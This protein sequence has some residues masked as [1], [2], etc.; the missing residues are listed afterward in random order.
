MSEKQGREKA[1]SDC[2]KGL[3][4]KPSMTAPPPRP[5][6]SFPPLGGRIH[7]S[8]L[9]LILPKFFPADMSGRKRLS[10]VSCVHLMQKGST[11]SIMF[12][13]VSH[14]CASYFLHGMEGTCISGLWLH[15]MLQAECTACS[16]EMPQSLDQQHRL[17]PH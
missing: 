12:T 2:G 14:I 6:P 15:G 1:A 11:H 5:L 17:P 16:P 8:R 13:P 3:E 4:T 7:V 9:C 10:A